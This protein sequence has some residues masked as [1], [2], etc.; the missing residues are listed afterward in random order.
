V[1][2]KRREEGKVPKTREGDAF[3]R[4]GPSRGRGGKRT[5]EKVKNES[6]VIKKGKEF[7]ISLPARQSTPWC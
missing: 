4:T 3:A 5:M 2:K 7:G 1:G 6:R